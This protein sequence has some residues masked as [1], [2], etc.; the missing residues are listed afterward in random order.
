MRDFRHPENPSEKTE[1]K[2]IFR[3]HNWQGTSRHG[4]LGQY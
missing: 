3:R 1:W 2:L 4:D